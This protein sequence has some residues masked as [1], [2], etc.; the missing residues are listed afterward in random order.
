MKDAVE[1]GHNYYSPSLGITEL[2]EAIIKLEKAV[3]GVS[4]QVEDV[5]VTNGL[6]EAIMAIIGAL[7]NPGEKIL[8]PSPTYPPYI[9][10][11]KFFGAIP[12]EYR[13]IEEEGWLPDVDDIRKRIDEKTK[14]IVIINP[15]NPTG[16]VY[17]SSLLRQIIDIAGEYELSVI[18]DEIYDRLVFEGE[19]APSIAEINTEVPR[20]VLNGF[21]KVYLATGWRV[22]YIYK[23]DED[24]FIDE[25]WNGIIKYLLIRISGVTP[26]QV[27]L[28]RTILSSNN[29]LMDYLS[30]LK[31]RRDYAYERIQG[32][33]GLSVIKP[34]GALYIF[35]KIE[36]N[37]YLDD[38]E[39]V[40]NLLKK[41]KVLVVNGSGFGREGRGHFRAVFLPPIKIQE[42]AY[43]RIEKFLS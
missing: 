31:K 5:V 33:D 18:S 7:L 26:A 13:T 42:E 14:A 36:T 23:L 29:Y 2:R 32:I 39:F 8:V 16:A 20:L 37:K 4:I 35:P 12:V 38:K 1:K 34:K 28:A 15:N 25:V 3:R 43:N 10:A 11:T 19:R 21:S 24:G 9:S 22:G 17:K 6:S 40:I 27:A 30:E 41:E